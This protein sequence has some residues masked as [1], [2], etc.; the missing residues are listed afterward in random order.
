[1]AR[2]FTLA[3]LNKFI[4]GQLQLTNPNFDE[5][6]IM[7]NIKQAKL[8]RLTF[9]LLVI[10]FLLAM[11]PSVSNAQTKTPL[12]EGTEWAWV[13]PVDYGTGTLHCFYR[14]DSE[15]KITRRVIAIAGDRLRLG[16]DNDML[17]ILGRNE[18]KMNYLPPA[19]SVKE[20]IGKYTQNGNSV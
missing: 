10:S 19:V 11:T 13:A 2:L 17:L 6:I 8:A 15:Q 9:L 4:S 20:R 7:K 12:L 3:F 14:F 5:V 18:L 1:M 16:I